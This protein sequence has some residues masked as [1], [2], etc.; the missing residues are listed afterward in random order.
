M[1][2][3]LRNKYS[4]LQKVKTFTDRPHWTDRENIA[5]SKTLRAK[6]ENILKVHN[7]MQ[8]TD[9]KLFLTDR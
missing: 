3:N 8:F 4:S 9:R 6:P 7:D 2:C 1:T 5:P